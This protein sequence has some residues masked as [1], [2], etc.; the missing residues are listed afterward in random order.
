MAARVSWVLEKVVELQYSG[1]LL[2]QTMHI[3]SLIRK[4]AM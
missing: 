4:Y 1:L 3:C 2:A